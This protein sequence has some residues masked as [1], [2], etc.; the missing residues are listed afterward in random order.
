MS[1]VSPIS[2]AVQDFFNP[3]KNVVGV[4][5]STTTTSTVTET[6]AETLG[7][8]KSTFG[9]VEDRS[10]YS[11]FKSEFQDYS[12]AVKNAFQD[13]P[14]LDDAKNT[15]AQYASDK[16]YDPSMTFDAKFGDVTTTPM[17]DGEVSTV[18]ATVTGTLSRY[19]AD[20]NATEVQN[21]FDE[22]FQLTKRTSAT[23][24]TA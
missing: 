19:N 21:T 17:E 18:E 7:T 11:N 3:N 22:T 10:A 23:S 20:A 2:N 14:T 9:S 5:S 8:T 13:Q 1:L 6:T 12:K 15:V 16:N 24:V 4:G